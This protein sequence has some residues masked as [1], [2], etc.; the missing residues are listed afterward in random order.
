MAMPARIRKIYNSKHL[1][2]YEFTWIRDT[3][4]ARTVIQ[5]NLVY[6]ES[7]NQV[8]KGVEFIMINNGSDGKPAARGPR[9]HWFILFWDII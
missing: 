4:A 8:K 9:S 6:E 7:G 2:S 3:A 5:A 1:Q